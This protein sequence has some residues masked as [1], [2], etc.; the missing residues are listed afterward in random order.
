MKLEVSSKEI[1]Y[2]INEMDDNGNGTVE[3][4][5]F[6]PVVAKVILS[7][8]AI[9]CST[10]E[11]MQYFSFVKTK[12]N[13]LSEIVNIDV[14]AEILMSKLQE[15]DKF[16]AGV[17]TDDQMLK[18]LFS[19]KSLD[20]NPSEL[21]LTVEKIPK[22]KDGKKLYKAY[23]ASA[24]RQIRHTM[25][26]NSIIKQE[27][28]GV[29][30]K[31]L[32]QACV[33]EE[34]ESRKANGLQEVVEGI[35]PLT[36]L[37]NIIAELKLEGGRKLSRLE[38]A[39]LSSTFVGSETH[40]TGQLTSYDHVSNAHCV[41]YFHY[42]PIVSRAIDVMNKSKYTS[43]LEAVNRLVIKQSEKEW[44]DDNDASMTPPAPSMSPKSPKNAHKQVFARRFSSILERLDVDQ[45][46][47][48]ELDEFIRILISLDLEFPDRD[49][50]QEIM[51][52]IDTAHNGFL[53]FNQLS[54]YLAQNMSKLELRKHVTS[55]SIHLHRHTASAKSEHHVDGKMDYISHLHAIFKIADLSGVGFVD[56]H[57]VEDVLSQL[58]INV[59]TFQ[60]E[61]I[62]S[63]LHPNEV[64]THSPTHSL[65]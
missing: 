7:F 44:D 45:H 16:D 32:L 34:L 57:V 30:Q 4:N 21:Y 9:V 55:M 37:K 14:M 18:A 36:S 35:I 46:R 42:V 20:L 19:V 11:C 24:F 56:F 15:Q 40:H 59:S 43:I 1:S 8:R 41:H 31:E 23:F 12:V 17:L 38:I 26:M 50:Y 51:D 49:A 63:H 61:T 48:V 5:E 62:L 25:M 64:L 2:V 6:I 28:T 13:E 54:D 52:N 58:D 39:L 53:T 33:Y 65:T 47:N 60:L 29:V 27:T 10:Q 3:M 22:D